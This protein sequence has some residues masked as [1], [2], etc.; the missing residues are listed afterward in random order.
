[1]ALEVGS[2]Y[3]FAVTRAH[4]FDRSSG[5]RLAGTGVDRAP[6]GTATRCPEPRPAACWTAAA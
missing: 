6:A 3:P 2:T 1:M 4:R 5:A